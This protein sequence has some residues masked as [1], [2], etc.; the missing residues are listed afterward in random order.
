MAKKLINLEFLIYNIINRLY[1]WIQDFKNYYKDT[2][3]N[4][5]STKKAFL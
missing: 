3:R 4:R 1:I 2:C 5:N